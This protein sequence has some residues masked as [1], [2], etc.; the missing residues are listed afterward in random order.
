MSWSNFTIENIKY[1]KNNK[2]NID[3][4]NPLLVAIKKERV[5]I[6]DF[7][8]RNKLNIKI[9]ELVGIEL[10]IINK[11]IL[12][13]TNVDWVDSKNLITDMINLDK[14][15]KLVWKTPIDKDINVNTINNSDNKLF[16]KTTQDNMIKLV[17]RLKILIYIGEYL[18]YKSNNTTKVFDIYVILSNLKRFFPENNK[19][20]IMVKNVNGGYTEIGRASCRE[21]V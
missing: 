14:T 19:Q 16:I 3:K 12:E 15:Y 6:K 13:Y 18:K 17:K 2:I 9:N 5:N 21:R 1:F 10:K 4:S 20:K 11:N 8:G 7:I